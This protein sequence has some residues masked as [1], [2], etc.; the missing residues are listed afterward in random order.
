MCDGLPLQQYCKVLKQ[1]SRVRHKVQKPDF[2]QTSSF[3]KFVSSDDGERKCEST[4]E[5]FDVFFRTEEKRQP[6]TAKL[7]SIRSNSG[8]LLHMRN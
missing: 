6:P 7:E 4:F 3:E 2:S 5:L 1:S 8:Y